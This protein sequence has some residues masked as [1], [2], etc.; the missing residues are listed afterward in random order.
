LA[1][2]NIANRKHGLHSLRHSLATRLLEAN[3]PL[4][5]I[6]EVLGHVNSASTETYLKVDIEHLRKCALNPEVFINGII[7]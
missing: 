7:V 5:V 6:S 1:D 2:V 4:P 3:T